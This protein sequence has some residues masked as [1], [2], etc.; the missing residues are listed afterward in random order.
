MLFMQ[1]T[2]S[3][4]V[5]EY[6]GSCYDASRLRLFVFFLQVTLHDVELQTPSLCFCVI[7]IGPHWGRTATVMA[8]PTV[9]WNWEV[10]LMQRDKSESFIFPDRESFS[11]PCS[12]CSASLTML[13]TSNQRLTWLYC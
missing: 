10:G 2:H 11:V 6:R 9:A 13:Y 12:S 4:T 1:F 8:A 3:W 7:K 5:F